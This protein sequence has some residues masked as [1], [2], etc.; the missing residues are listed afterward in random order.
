MDGKKDRYTLASEL[1]HGVNA[2][3]IVVTKDGKEERY[4]NGGDV[5]LIAGNV[6]MDLGTSMNEGLNIFLTY[7]SEEKDRGMFP[8]DIT[9]VDVDGEE[10]ESGYVES[11]EFLRQMMVSLG[12]TYSDLINNNITLSLLK[13]IQ[14]HEIPY[15]IDM[16]D[17]LDVVAT[18]KQQGA[19]NIDPNIWWNIIIDFWNG[20]T[21]HLLKINGVHTKKEA[22]E[23]FEKYE[24]I[25][26][27]AASGCL[28]REVD[29]EGFL[30]EFLNSIVQ[31]YPERAQLTSDTTENDIIL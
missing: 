30:N 4:I 6:P 3:E 15:S 22:E 20:F 24:D 27:G 28:M 8:E 5:Y 2:D 25:F 26:K 23:V 1:F 14:E 10:Y 11:A 18:M 29:F 13:K 7:L 19:D 21:N 17:A 12:I 16:I 9:I 31:Q